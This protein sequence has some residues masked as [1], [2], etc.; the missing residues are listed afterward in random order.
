MYIYK[1][2]EKDTIKDN[3]LKDNRIFKEYLRIFK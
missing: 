1:K 2:N 3:F